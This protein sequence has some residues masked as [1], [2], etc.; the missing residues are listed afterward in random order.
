MHTGNQYTGKSSMFWEIMP[1]GP[2]KV[3]RR[4]GGTCHL[5]IKPSKKSA[6][7]RQRAWLEKK[8][9]LYRSRRELGSEPVNSHWLY[10]KTEASH[11]GTSHVHFLLPSWLTVQS[12]RWREYI[13]LKRQLTFNGPHSVISQKT[14]LFI[15]TAVGDAEENIW[16]EEGWGD[17]RLEK[18]A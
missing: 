8:V 3:N 14:E 7:Y 1:C 15:T 11:Q 2:L 4:F 10:Q 12:W 13:P 5:K 17:R 9:E 6:W 18:T 16:T